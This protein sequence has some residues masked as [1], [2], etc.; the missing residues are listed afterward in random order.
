M[1]FTIMVVLA[2]ALLLFVLKRLGGDTR[3]EMPAG[4]DVAP[5]SQDA[6]EN[7]GR[8]GRKIEAIKLYRERH[9]V[10]LKEAKEAVERI[11]RNPATL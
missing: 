4:A 8:S 5:P 11:G 9:N 7:A 2:I 3:I 6:I 1:Q 10:G